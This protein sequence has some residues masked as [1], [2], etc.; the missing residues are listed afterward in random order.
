MKST[1]TE[2]LNRGTGRNSSRTHTFVTESLQESDQGLITCPR[3]EGLD[4]A[5]MAFASKPTGNQPIAPRHSKRLRFF[6]SD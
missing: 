3:Y 1:R 2:L 5:S 6:G 4:Y